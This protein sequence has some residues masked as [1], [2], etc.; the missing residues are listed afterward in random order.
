MKKTDFEI[1]QL[2]NTTFNVYKRK[3]IMFIFSLWL[4]VTE[5]KTFEDATN[6]VDA[7]CEK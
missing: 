3:R 5:F 2:D 7:I 4:F 1:Q 6:F